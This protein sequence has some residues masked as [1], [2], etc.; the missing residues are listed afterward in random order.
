V[1]EVL[2]VLI[3]I[4]IFYKVWE[5]A[6]RF[7]EWREGV[8]DGDGEFAA[9]FLVVFETQIG[10]GD[11]LEIKFDG[12]LFQVVEVLAELLEVRIGGRER[13]RA[14]GMMV[15]EGVLGA[16][17]VRDG[18]L[19][20]AL[21]AGEQPAGGVRKVVTFEYGDGLAFDDLEQVLAV[22]LGDGFGE[23]EDLLVGQEHRGNEFK[24]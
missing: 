5:I 4:G 18:D 19:Q 14:A 1:T 2:I 21:G 12:L 8:E 6:S 7:D 23:G 16:A 3:R 9:G 10:E 20:F 24:V 15:D 22:E 13:A 17:E 11:A